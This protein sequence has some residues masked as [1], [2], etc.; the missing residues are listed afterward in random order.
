MEA[1]AYSDRLDGLPPLER[2]NDGGSATGFYQ[3]QVAGGKKHSRLS[4][5]SLTDAAVPA[6]QTSARAASE[7]IGSR[8]RLQHRLQLLRQQPL[9]FRLQVLEVRIRRDGRLHR[10]RTAWRLAHC[11]LQCAEEASQ[12]RRLIGWFEPR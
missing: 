4:G 5:W 3:A 2:E 11:V 6:K 12:H 1:S 7:Q 9:A 8:H 10:A